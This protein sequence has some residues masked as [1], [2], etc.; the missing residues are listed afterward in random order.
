MANYKT[1]MECGAEL[2]ADDIAIHRKLVQRN[3]DEFFCIDCLG[4][5]M[6]STRQELEKLID[7]YR[8]SGQCTL[9]R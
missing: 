5:L 1:C 4:E 6:G 8:K 2:L 9:F 3:A 7:Y